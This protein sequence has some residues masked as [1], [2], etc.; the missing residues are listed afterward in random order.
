MISNWTRM[1]ILFQHRQVTSFGFLAKALWACP[2]FQN[3]STLPTHQK[4]LGAQARFTWHSAQVLVGHLIQ[5]WLSG[6]VVD[7]KLRCHLFRSQSDEVLHWLPLCE[8]RVRLDEPM[9]ECAPRG[10][11]PPLHKYS[12]WQRASSY[13]WS[14]QHTN[15]V[16]ASFFKKRKT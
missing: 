1:N 9:L 12:T 6:C 15:A 4:N 7:Q 8:Y 16:L 5:Q 10:K 3:C 2:C 13:L 14:K 11:L